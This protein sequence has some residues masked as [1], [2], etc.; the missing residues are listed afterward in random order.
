MKK[1]VL[2]TEEVLLM[3]LASS[4][5]INFIGH[6]QVAVDSNSRDTR[7]K[8]AYKSTL[9]NLYN[10]ISLLNGKNYLLLNTVTK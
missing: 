10:L 4:M 3:H 5:N 8:N 9:Q 7:V 2:C 1:S 6:V